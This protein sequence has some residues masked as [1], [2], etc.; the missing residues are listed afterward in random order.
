M[1]R[2]LYESNKYNLNLLLF[3]AGPFSAI[4]LDVHASGSSDPRSRPTRKLPRVLPEVLGGVPMYFLDHPPIT[5]SSDRQSPAT[6][7][8]PP[9]RRINSKL[10]LA[11]TAEDEPS[12]SPCAPASNRPRSTSHIWTILTA[13]N[14]GV[15]FQDS[16]GRF[17]RLAV[18]FRTRLTRGDMHHCLRHELRFSGVESH[19]P[20]ASLFRP[21]KASCLPEIGAVS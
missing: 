12:I 7:R 15:D 11:L 5:P 8:A 13:R 21:G 17:P 3:A 2:L 19:V 1:P 10:L 14:K 6:N 20:M 9:S 18:S 4:I 16:F